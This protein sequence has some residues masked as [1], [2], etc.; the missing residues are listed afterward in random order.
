MDT[1]GIFAKQPVPG[2]VKTR[3]AAVLGYDLAA[4]AAE[5]FLLDLAVRFQGTGERRFL[6]YAPDNEESR[7]WFRSVGA[8]EYFLWPQPELDLGGRMERF[9]REQLGSPAD[10]VVIIGADSPTL[11]REFVERA[12]ESLATADCVLGPATDGGY[13]LVGLRGKCWPIF[14]GIEWSGARVFEQTVAHVAGLGAKLALLLPWYD[15]DSPDDW[16]LLRG[17]VRGL[18]TTGQ[19][20]ESGRPMKCHSYD[21]TARVLGLDTENP[22]RAI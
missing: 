15:V 14:S 1:L 22:D 7:A 8:E 3:L 10:R 21:A 2:Q 4:Q 20:E 13:Y 17:H 19:G 6:C 12:F 5:A 11:P 9:F 18:R 16:Q